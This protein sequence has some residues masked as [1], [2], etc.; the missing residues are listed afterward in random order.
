MIENRTHNTVKRRIEVPTNIAHIG[1]PHEPTLKPKL[2]IEYNFAN[3][4]ASK[5]KHYLDFEVFRKLK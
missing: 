5:L 1:K 4:H 3:V 2:A